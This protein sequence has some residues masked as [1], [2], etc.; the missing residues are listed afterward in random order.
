MLMGGNRQ[1]VFFKKVVPLKFV[2]RLKAHSSKSI[3][4]IVTRE[5]PQKASLIAGTFRGVPLGL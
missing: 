4:W 3:N 1:W 2:A 5:E